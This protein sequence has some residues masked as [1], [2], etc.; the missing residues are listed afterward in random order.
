ISGVV[1]VTLTPM[2]CSRFLRSVHEAKHGWFYRI[3]EHFFQGMLHV[4]DVTLKQALRFRLATMAISFLVLAG[5][6]Y[7]FVTIPKGFIPDQDTDQLQIYTEA[8]QGTSYYQMMEYEQQIA[9][10]VANNPNVESLMASVGGATSQK[11]GG[12]NYGELMI[13]LKPRS[14]R[15]ATIDQVMKEL[16]PPL[17]SFAG[18]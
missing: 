6:L 4:Y 12:P 16:R 17:S 10:T 15:K 2:L 11:L 13:H 5:T 1:S 8:A 7:M 9:Q 3:T 14:E 18:M